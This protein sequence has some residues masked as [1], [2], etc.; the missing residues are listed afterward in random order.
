M[1]PTEII[2]FTAKFEKKS[3]SSNSVWNFKIFAVGVTAGLLGAIFLG[4][5]ILVIQKCPSPNSD[6]ANFN[7]D[8]IIDYGV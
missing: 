7:Y 5:A 3:E 4:I 8:A 1:D 6:Q 2:S